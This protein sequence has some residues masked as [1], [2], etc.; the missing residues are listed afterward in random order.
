MKRI[1]IYN[2]GF[3]F[4]LMFFAVSISQQTFGQAVQFNEKKIIDTEAF[5]GVEANG[6]LKV[7]LIQADVFQVSSEADAVDKGTLNVEVRDNILHLN[8]VSRQHTVPTVLVMAP[9]FTKLAA[10]GVSQLESIEMLYLDKLQVQTEGATYNICRVCFQI[11]RRKFRCTTH[12]CFMKIHFT[13]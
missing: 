4:I 5:T 8:A 2:L 1:K 13:S 10:Y 7:Q 9:D 3:A 11:F 6:A 12:F